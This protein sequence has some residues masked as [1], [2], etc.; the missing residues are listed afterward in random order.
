MKSG[1]SR[2]IRRGNIGHE[3]GVAVD[4]RVKRISNCLGL[5]QNDNPAKTR[6]DEGAAE[7]SLDLVQ[8]TDYSVWKDDLY[9]EKSEVRRMF[10]AKIL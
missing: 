10:L 2:R 3:Q 9:G 4:M 6:F 1:K 5:A 8:Y 7:R